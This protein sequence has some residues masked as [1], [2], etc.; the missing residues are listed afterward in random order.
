MKNIK[1]SLI[2]P[3][4]NSEEYVARCLDSLL[5]QT[6]KDIEIVCINDGSTDSSEQILNEYANKY[7]NIKVYNKENGGCGSARNMGIDNSKGEYIEFVDSDDE[8]KIDAAEKMYNSAK[9]YN[10]DLV[11]CGMERIDDVSGKLITC[12]MTNTKKE[13]INI[14]NENLLEMLFVNPGP[15]NKM[16]KREIFK[17]ARFP[18]I[19]VV[20]DLMLTLQYIPNI[21]IVSFVKEPLY[22]YKVR[23]ESGVNTVEYSTFEQMKNMF[24]EIKDKYKLENL[25]NKYI[26]YIDKM[27]YIH[28]GVSMLYRMC[29]NKDLN[30][31]DEISKTIKY[32][33]TN[34]SSWKNLK[35]VNKIYL[36]PY[37]K[38]LM[39]KT[40][41]FLYKIGLAKFFIKTYIFLITKL[42]IDI[43][44]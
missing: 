44:W 35:N 23:R 20:D 40:V 31:S 11:V 29:F 1:V 24:I 38:V 12:D 22:R 19:P 18:K 7:S 4:Y 5:K 13:V 34:F 28:I 15:C 8:L 27:A 43:K 2:V 14:E 16:H 6:L 25:D 39:F 42:N 17:N 21:K 30:K 26:D 41:N 37:V 36:T 33:D 10:S 9:K 3:I 32:L